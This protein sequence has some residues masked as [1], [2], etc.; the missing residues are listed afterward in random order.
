[1]EKSVFLKRVGSGY[2]QSTI[3][4]ITIESL[5]KKYPLSIC[6]QN[7]YISSLG[8]TKDLNYLQQEAGFSASGDDLKC[9]IGSFQFGDPLNIMVTKE[10]WSRWN[11]NSENWK[12]FKTHRTHLLGKCFQFP[13]CCIQIMYQFMILFSCLEADPQFNIIQSWT[14]F[15]RRQ[16]PFQDLPWPH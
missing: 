1:M 4:S 12:E 14:L 16:F 5:V 2:S 7:I 11:C 8:H 9:E 13:L 6:V 3:H 10:G 15:S